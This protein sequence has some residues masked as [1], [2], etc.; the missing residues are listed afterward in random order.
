MT[1]GL[2]VFFHGSGGT[3]RESKNFLENYPISE[4]NEL[5]V[6]DN[7][8]SIHGFEI[9]LWCPTAPRREYSP[10]FG[11]KLNVWHNRSA[12][13]HKLGKGDMEDLAGIE[14]SLSNVCRELTIK[15]ASKNYDWVVLGGFSM[16]GGFALQFLLKSVCERVAN[17]GS[18]LIGIFSIG[19]FLVDNSRVLKNKEDLIDVPILML[20]GSSD[21]L[22]QEDWGRFT[23]TALL[24]NEINVRFYTYSNV[25]H[26]MC[27]EMVSL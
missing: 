15:M 18:K 25:G 10:C 1:Q 21:D 23:A 16:G 19:S 9:D 22:V 4:L 20:H 12:N 13:F 24:I 17:L 14:E 3:G 8:T 6:I 5:S 7:L 11:E 26:D 2:L 27:D